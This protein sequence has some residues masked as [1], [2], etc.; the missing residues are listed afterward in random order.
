[1]LCELRNNKKLKRM[2]HFEGRVAC[3]DGYYLL[4]EVS[5]TVTNIIFWEMYRMLGRILYI[6]G[7]FAPH[8]EYYYHGSCHML[9]LMYGQI[10]PL[11]SW[12]ERQRVCVTRLDMHH[13]TWHCILL[14]CTSLSLVRLML[15]F[16]DL[17]RTFM[18]NL[19]LMN[20]EI[21]VENI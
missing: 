13:N 17:V 7:R 4:R 10:C 5:R 16:V 3:H 6:E 8:D 1:M 19:W 9:W 15:C 11:G 2:S 18:W 14:H 20:I 21:V 12:T